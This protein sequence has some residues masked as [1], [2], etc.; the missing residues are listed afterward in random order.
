MVDAP[1][2]ILR[3]RAKKLIERA[4]ER[5]YAQPPPES[6]LLWTRGVAARETLSYL[7][8]RGIDAGPAL[9]GAGLSRRQLSR[10]DTGLSVAS[11]YR[12]LELA[13]AAAND[14]FLGLHVAAEMDLRSIG[15]L[16]YLTGS[17]R[18]VSEALE[19]LARYSATTNEALVVEISRYKDEVTLATAKRRT[20]TSL[21]GS[22]SNFLRSGLFEHC[23]RRQTAISPC[24]G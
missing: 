24:R 3:I 20:S 22:F 21:T 16:F 18:T 23:T 12:F 2:S 7:D 10:D 5:G 14:Q 4:E 19:N 6:P 17:A 15:I 11:Q 9:F 8:R 1:S 13:A